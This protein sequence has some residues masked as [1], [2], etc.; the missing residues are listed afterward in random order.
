M[1]EIV[2][3]LVSAL[4]SQDV[5]Y[6][7]WKS[8][9]ALAE[10]CDGEGDLDL[11]FDRGQYPVV[12]AILARNGFK[13]LESR[14]DR[15]FP[16]IEDYVGFDEKSGRCVHVQAHYCLVTGQALIKNYHLAVERTLLQNLVV[17]PDTGVKIP[18]PQAEA[19][20]HVVRTCIKIDGS[21]TFRSGLYRK[22]MAEAAEELAKLESAAGGTGFQML[23]K[24][25]PSVPAAVFEPVAQAVRAQAPASVWRKR[26]SALLALLSEYRRR[27]PWGAMLA[28][29]V[30]RLYLAFFQRVLRR[31]PKR[32]LATGGFGIAIVGSDGAGKS[33]A[34]KGLQKFLGGHVDVHQC[35]MGKP[36]KSLPT[37][38]LAYSMS[39]LRRLGYPVDAQRPTHH[40]DG[41]WPAWLAW[42]PALLLWSLA[43]DRLR[44]WQRARRIIASGSV[45]IFDRYPVQGLTI[46]EG[47]H[48]AEVTDTSRKFY[49]ALAHAEESMYRRICLPE[50]TLALA[51]PPEVAAVRQAGDGHDY[52]M[53]RATAMLQFLETAPDG[54]KV[55]DASA[56]LEAVS[57]QIR[58]TVWAVL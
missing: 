20:I 29:S 18:D 40:P 46:M 3:T 50:L 43:R 19:I 44:S 10:A 54:L 25:F 16:G 56:S 34:I 42:L 31:N 51:V 12:T 1:L 49:A 15:Q 26:R 52:V 27:T 28:W 11:L 24:L 41:N 58:Q 32:Q 35:H 21:K 47:P 8:N 36:P 22:M 2:E 39:A 17:H 53:R 9:D 7:H 33:T 4:E 5:I 57:Q 38:V 6:C 13:R 37:A 55:I 45:V 14:L 23:A 48:I 30:R